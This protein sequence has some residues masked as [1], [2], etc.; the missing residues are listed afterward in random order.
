METVAEVCAHLATLTN[1]I[2]CSAPT[3]TFWEILWSSLESFGIGAAFG[4][5]GV[6]LFLFVLFKTQ[7]QELAFG[8]YDT[9]SRIVD[10][11]DEGKELTDA[12]MVMAR[13]ITFGAIAKAIVAAGVLI[14]FGMLIS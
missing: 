8:K 3:P 10:N 6:V 4:F 13:T 2:I 11:Y 14:F 12:D 1:D 5:A 9:Y 7:I